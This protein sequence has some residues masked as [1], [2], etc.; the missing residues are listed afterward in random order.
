MIPT[1]FQFAF[2]YL[3]DVPVASL[4]RDEEDWGRTSTGRKR[5]SLMNPQ[6]TH[7]RDVC[8]VAFEFTFQ[9]Q[10][11]DAGLVVCHKVDALHNRNT[12]R[13]FPG[14]DLPRAGTYIPSAVK[15]ASLMTAVTFLAGRLPPISS[16]ARGKVAS[17]K[18]ST[19]DVLKRRK[20]APIGCRTPLKLG[21]EI[22]G[23]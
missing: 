3:S 2:F 6:V 19:G 1:L 22:T 21:V 20:N 13:H 11:A 15:A 5:L 17:I 8:S 14:T 23:L 10:T 18:E 4:L 9:E 16:N 7:A 12:F